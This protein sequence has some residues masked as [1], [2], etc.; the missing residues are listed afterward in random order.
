MAWTMTGEV[1]EPT[2]KRAQ[3]ML[4]P[5]APRPQPQAD[6]AAFRRQEFGV[7]TTELSPAVVVQ[8][9]A[10]EISLFCSLSD[11]GLGAPTHLALPG[12]DGVRVFERGATPSRPMTEPWLVCWF[13]E[14]DGWVLWDAPVLVVL[15]HK[16][17]SIALTRDGLTLRFPNEAGLMAIMPLF[18]YGKLPL[19]PESDYLAKHG[20]PSAG[21]ATSRW[22]E[23][24]PK[25]VIDR[26]RYFTGMLRII[27]IYCREEFALDGD[28]LL[29]RSRFRWLPIEDDWHTKP[30]KLA[31]LPPTLAL[32][33]W[34][35]K[36]SAERPFPMTFSDEIRDPHLFTAYGPYAGVE[37]ADGYTVRMKVLQY[38][39]MAEKP[40]PADVAAYPI[41]A[42][43]LNRL[44]DKL[45]SKFSRG[46]WQEVWD[47]GGPENYC[48]QAMGDRWYAKAIPY[49]PADVQRRLKSTLTSYLREF[50]LQERN[51]Q[52]FRGM[53]LLT[54]PGI[55][56]WG[57][58]DDAGKFS[59]N[60]LETIWN[61]DRCVGCRDL[62]RDRWPTIKRFF[63]TPLES[64]WKSVGRSAIAEMG[65][66]AA[67][68]LAMARL[69]HEVGDRDTYAFACYIFAREL[70]H[71]Y[72]KQVGADYFRRNQPWHSEEFM[73]EEVYLTNM[74]G[75][76]ASW[77][78]D[79]PTYPAK[80]G[81]RQYNNRWVRFSCEEVARFYQDVLPR[82]VRAEM[83]RLT[84]RAKR[85]ECPYKL[86]EDTAHIAPSIVRLRALLLGE[87]PE[88]LAQL[89][90]PEKW[91]VG[92]GADVTAMC[93]PFLRSTRPP[94]WERIV[95]PTKT[96]FALGLERCVTGGF[97]ALT[98]AA[99]ERGGRPFLRWWG[100]RAPK[101]LKGVDGGEWWSFGQIVPAGGPPKR[102][103]AHRLNWN[104]Q[105]WVFGQ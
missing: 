81:E 40:Q 73:P 95:P 48:W 59:S 96:D 60:L 84:E 16:P 27:P 18:G 105:V 104:T 88:K 99:G 65:D 30:I 87:S 26:C 101:Q 67:P 7:L 82:E 102:V 4:S 6:M 52:G 13:N 12:K 62:I 89:A 17:E 45:D 51:Y 15:Q 5:A 42:P 97:P 31:P 32:A 90:A 103:E 98:L 47:H 19:S 79:G 93:V 85:D 64:D 37:N 94:V 43:V 44:Q 29:I 58:Y 21:L 56:T 57:S 83:D 20:L 36:H 3:L 100:W 38:I 61:V 91:Q 76:L 14:A 74:W 25:P 2:G 63:I 80:T 69:A 49:L 8:S 71:H 92:R 10:A 55:G 78:I 1:A 28:D 72:V 50:M 68:P 33:W 39:H 41:A 35:G 22:S 66:E 11:W 34:A 9:K 24:L 77:Q 53:L 75:D 86:L 70:V 23:A 46:Q 54:G